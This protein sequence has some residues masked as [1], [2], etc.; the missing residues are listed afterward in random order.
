[1]QNQSYFMEVPAH[2]NAVLTSKKISGMMQSTKMTAAMNSMQAQLKTFSKALKN[3]TIP[4]KN[5][6]V[7]YV[8]SISIMREN[9][10]LQRNQ[11]KKMRPTTRKC[12]GQ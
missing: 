9:H 4:K 5:I 7:G 2:Y 6:T 1:M 3:S 12:L 10:V 8:G 11:D